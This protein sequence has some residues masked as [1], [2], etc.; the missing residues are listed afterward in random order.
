MRPYLPYIAT[1][2]L[3]PLGAVIGLLDES[4]TLMGTSG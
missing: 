4:P 1:L 2:L 3:A